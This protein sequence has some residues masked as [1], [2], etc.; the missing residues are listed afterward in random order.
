MHFYDEWAKQILHGQWTDHRA[1]Y[2]LPLYPYALALLY[3]L[4][5]YSHFVPELIQAFLDAGTS[6]LIYKICISIFGAP[7]IS[8]PSDGEMRNSYRAAAAKFFAVAAAA[9]WT[10]FVPAQRRFSSFGF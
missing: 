9:G 4:F 2:G 3:R 5:G 8:D 7:W 1:F 6:L 10:F